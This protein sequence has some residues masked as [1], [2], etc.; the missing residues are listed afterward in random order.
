MVR[1]QYGGSVTA[2]TSEA[3]LGAENVD[4]FLVGRA[5]L[6]TEQF[7]TVVIHR[8]GPRRWHLL[9]LR[10]RVEA[11]SCDPCHADGRVSDAVEPTASVVGGRPV[12]SSGPKPQAPPADRAALC[13]RRLASPRHR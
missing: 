1:I 10:G 2:G 4:G 7:G 11:G 5:G 3:L 6:D 8:A 12:C 13:P 9:R